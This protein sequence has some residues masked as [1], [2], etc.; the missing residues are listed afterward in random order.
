MAISEF[1]EI[2]YTKLL[3][4]FCE[5]QGPPKHIHDQLKWGFSVN[6]DNQ[7]IELFE[8]RPHF[9]EPSRKIESPIAKANFV[10]SKNQ[11]KVYWM[12]GNGKWVL[13][14]PCPTVRTLDEFLKLVKED[15]HCCF[16]G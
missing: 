13:Y 11:W 5:E 2:R 14:E 8:I 1:E 6:A 3:K 16:F 9:L 12:R 15:A 7:T 10:K 4:D